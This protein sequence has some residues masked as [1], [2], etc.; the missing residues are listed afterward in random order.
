L[1]DLKTSDTR[2][3][4]AGYEAARNL[5]TSNGSNTAPCSF[6][7]GRDGFGCPCKSQKIGDT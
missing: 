1:S 5:S 7:D 2:A 3:R 6:D 4:F